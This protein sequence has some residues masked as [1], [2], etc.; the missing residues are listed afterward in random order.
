LHIV[1]FGPYIPQQVIEDWWWKNYASHRSKMGKV[2]NVK[3]QA[4][5]LSKYL[6]GE[7]FERCYFSKGWVFPG[8]IGFSKWFKK[9]FGVYPPREM[10]VALAKMSG[11]EREEHPWFGVYSWEKKQRKGKNQNVMIIQ[12]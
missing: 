12:R 10:L 1:Y 2:Y 4:W 11:A 8:W 6:S 9:E 5:Y 7:D 3:G